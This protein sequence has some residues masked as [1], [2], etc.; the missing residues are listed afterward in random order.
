MSCLAL[1]LKAEGCG[2]MFKTR[3]LREA[4]PLSAF[5]DV[6]THSRHRAMFC[7]V[8]FFPPSHVSLMGYATARLHQL[9]VKDRKGMRRWSNYAQGT[10]TEMANKTISLGNIIECIYS[11]LSGEIQRTDHRKKKKKNWKRSWVCIFYSVYKRESTLWELWLWKKK[12]NINET[13]TKTFAKHK[14]FFT[15]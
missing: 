6:W 15:W 1:V 9:T 7:F 5:I 13:A 11:A 4:S 3:Q 14:S 10:C 8:L 2:H 12:K